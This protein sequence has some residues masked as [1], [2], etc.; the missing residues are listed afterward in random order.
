MGMKITVKIAKLA[1]DKTHYQNY[2][3][4][5]LLKQILVDVNVYLAVSTIYQYT[6]CVY[7]NIN[8]IC[9]TGA[10]I[11]VYQKRFYL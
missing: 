7:K 1:C 11:C 9:V 3:E 5:T 10:F 8:N 2:T 6:Y 4:F